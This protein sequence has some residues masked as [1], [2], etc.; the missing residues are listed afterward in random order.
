MG[1]QEAIKPHLAEGEKI[2]AARAS[3]SDAIVVTDRRIIDIQRGTGTTGRDL[4]SVK[5]TIFTGD[6]VAGVRVTEIGEEPV[7]VTQILVG[8][9]IGV[10]GVFIALVLNDS[11]GELGGFI[12]AVVGL[13]GFAIAI[14]MTYEAFQT[15]D[16]HVRVSLTSIEG[17]TIETVTLAED[18]ADVATSISEAVGKAHSA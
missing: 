7:D 2:N 9:G 14:W 12:A 10:V 11:L 15:S 4:Q 5:S 8:T 3:A 13:T 6:E 16:G 18:E 1:I 17:D